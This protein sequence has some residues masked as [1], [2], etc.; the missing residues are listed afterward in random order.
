LG[1]LAALLSV[2]AVQAQSNPRSIKRLNDSDDPTLALTGPIARVSGDAAAG[3]APLLAGDCR[4]VRLAPYGA[5]YAGLHAHAAA[6]RVLPPGAGL[7]EIV[8][9]VSGQVPAAT[10]VAAYAPPDITSELV[11]RRGSTDGGDPITIAGTNFGLAPLRVENRVPGG[12]VNQY[13]AV[14]AMIAAGLHGIDNK[15]ELEEITEGNAYTADKVRVPTNLRDAAALFASSTIAQDA[16][17]AEV[18]EHYANNARIE[19]AAY[20]SA[21]T[22][23]ERVRGFER[24]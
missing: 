12:D 9:F 1:G 20:D 22:D 18:V 24:L 19:I 4:G 10:L 2:A 6:T 3:S 13:L 11:P 8:P 7:R 21:V 23:W 17:G 14:A 5:R 15:L 16:F